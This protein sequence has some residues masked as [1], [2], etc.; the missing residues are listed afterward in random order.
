MLP[1]GD[2]LILWSWKLRL[3]AAHFGLLK[4]LN[5]EANTRVALLAEVLDSDFQ[6][7]IGLLLP[8][9]VREDYTWNTRHPLGCLLVL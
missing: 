1:Q 3:L 7:E 5:Q 9:E 4:Q 8:N 6:V 2:T